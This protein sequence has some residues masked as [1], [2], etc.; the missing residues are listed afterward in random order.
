MPKWSIVKEGVGAYQNKARNTPFVFELDNE[1]KKK[2][3]VIKET[4]S[5]LLYWLDG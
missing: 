4:C 1:C 5:W 3:L 2:S